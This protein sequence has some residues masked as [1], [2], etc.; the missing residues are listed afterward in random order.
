MSTAKKLEEKALLCELASLFY[1]GNIFQG[2]KRHIR[3]ESWCHFSGW[4]LGEIYASYWLAGGFCVAQNRGPR[5][6]VR[7]ALASGRDTAQEGRAMWSR[8][9]KLQGTQMPRNKGQPCSAAVPRRD[10]EAQAVTPGVSPRPHWL[11]TLNTCQ[12]DAYILSITSQI[13]SFSHLM[14]T[15]FHGPQ[16]VFRE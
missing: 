7:A 13:G 2:E 1:P 8:C 11:P 6:E 14:Q 4:C 3:E 9:R 15:L 16:E 12:Q 10:W 5:G